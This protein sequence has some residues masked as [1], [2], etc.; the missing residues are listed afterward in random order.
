VRQPQAG[1]HRVALD[2]ARRRAGEEPDPGD[3]EYPQDGHQAPQQI[4]RPADP[5]RPVILH[6]QPWS[7]GDV[8]LVGCARVVARVRPRPG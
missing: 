8:N 3:H 2:A 4:D 1:V 7:P 6:D 5:A